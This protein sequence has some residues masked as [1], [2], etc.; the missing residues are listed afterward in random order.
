MTMTTRVLSVSVPVADQDAALRFYTEVLGCEVR[1]DVEVWP[2]A[3]MVEVVPPGSTVS[4]VLL[5]P[6]G[7]IPVAVRLGTPD[8]RRAHERL[9][10][11]GAILHNEELVLMDGVPPMFSF[12]DP[13]G[14]GL[15]YLE[16]AGEAG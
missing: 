3:R 1:T 11:S 5:P 12:A 4:L 6:D 16:D 9:R 7:Q 14:N 13:D 2:G 15:V 10:E 8:A